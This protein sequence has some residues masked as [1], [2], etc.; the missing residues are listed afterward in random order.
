MS[1]KMQVDKFRVGAEIGESLTRR[2]KNQEMRRS[3]ATAEG[4]TTEKPRAV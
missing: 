2:T 3:E 4:L 1:T